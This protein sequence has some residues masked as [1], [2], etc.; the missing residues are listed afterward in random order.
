MAAIRILLAAY[1]GEAYLRQQLD[2]VLAQTC[3]DF[4]LIV[5]D[6]QSRD[7]TPRILEEYAEK[8]PDQILYYRSGLRFGSAQGH[9]MHLLKTF[10]QSDYIMFCDQDDVWHPDKVEKTLEQMKKVE[11]DPSVPVLV[12]TDLRVVNGA[13]EQ[14]DP[15]FMHYA[16]IRGEDTRLCRL[17]ARNVVTGCTVMINRALAELACVPE[18][19]SRVRM[20]DWYLAQ[21]AAACGTLAYLPEA[22]MDYRIHG[23]NVVGG[24]N[25]P[26]LGKLI[27][28]ALSTDLRGNIRKNYA[29]ARF[30]YETHRAQMTPEGAATVEKYVAMEDYGFF[31]RRFWYLKGGY[32]MDGLPKILGQLIWG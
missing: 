26:A 20:H 31:R 14:I 28:K 3:R 8:Y 11:E 6:D 9:F 18:D 25:D 32:L 13:L 30:L 5:S 7:E 12:Y 23:G 27:K 10:S 4:Q 17:L 29:Q 1:N 24:S 16:R 21:L 22:T 19:Y 15:S 2:S